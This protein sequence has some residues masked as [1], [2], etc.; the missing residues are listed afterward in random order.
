[1]SNNEVIAKQVKLLKEYYHILEYPDNV[2]CVCN[3]CDLENFL[4]AYRNKLHYEQ[5][6]LSGL[7]IDYPYHRASIVGFDGSD[8]IQ[9]F[10][11]DPTYGQFFK[12]KNF[13]NYMFNNYREFSNKLLKNGFIECNIENINSYI[14][15]FIFSDA[16]SKNS[17]C[18]FVY[19]KL[20]NLLLNIAAINKDD[21]FTK[22]KLQRKK[23]GK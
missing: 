21:K 11:I 5:I 14:N 6:L 23:A 1:M 17:N 12:N 10:L 9:W 16:F 8:G 2:A 19:D 7:G 3:E 15:G 22:K 13:N 20:Y 4:F 18:N